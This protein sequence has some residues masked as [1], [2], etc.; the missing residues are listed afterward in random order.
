MLLVVRQLVDQETLDLLQFGGIEPAGGA[1]RQ[2]RVTV[3]TEPHEPAIFLLGERATTKHAP[4]TSDAI[5]AKKTFLFRHFETS[6]TET[7][8]DQ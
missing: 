8:G 4:L 2:R 6:R 1:L 7:T 3:Q 5:S